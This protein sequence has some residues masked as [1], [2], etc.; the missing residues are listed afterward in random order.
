[1]IVKMSLLTAASSAVVIGAFAAPI[2]FFGTDLAPG[3]SAPSGPVQVPDTSA[4]VALL[5]SAGGLFA[6]NFD[7]YASGRSPGYA[8]GMNDALGLV[9]PAS[10]VTAI[11]ASSGE[12][13]EG[14]VIDWTGNGPANPQPTL[15]AAD[16]NALVDFA[17]LADIDASSDGDEDGQAPLHLL[18][19]FADIGPEL[20][21]VDSGPTIYYP[22]RPIQNADPL[23]P[24][25]SA[26]PSASGPDEQHV[27]HGNIPADLPGGS[28]GDI[29]G[30]IPGDIP[31]STPI[32]IPDDMLVT[33][34][35]PVPEPAASGLLG[36]GLLGLAG[37]LSRRRHAT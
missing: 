8:Y 27:G 18:P 7:A 35:P 17:T 10:V 24:S 29:S 33:P 2:L 23:D 22:A 26:A 32:A 14:E 19:R 36:L 34:A 12:T 9:G 30:H 3:E 16:T 28:P 31:G 6:G 15:L 5:P 4:H 20:R 11:L 13:V 1:M 37:S 21:L 25:D